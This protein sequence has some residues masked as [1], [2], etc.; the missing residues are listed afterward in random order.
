MAFTRAFGT[1]G[2]FAAPVLLVSMGAVVASFAGAGCGGDDTDPQAQGTG[3]A[4]A[5]SSAQGPGGANGATGGGQPEGVS[6]PELG[7]PVIAAY[8]EHGLLHLTCEADDDCYAALG[9]FHASNRFFFMDFIR[10]LV[11]GRLG[12]LVKAGATVLDLDF[13]NRHFF[14]TRKGEP[15]EE[16]LYEKASDRVKG[17][18]DAFTR[19]V[20]AW[21][22]DMRK[23]RNGATLTK[24]YEFALLVKEAIRDWEPADSAAVGL[25]VLNSLSNNSGSELALAEELPL[26]DPTLA[27]DLFSFRPVF[28]AFTIPLG[29]GS[30]VPGGPGAPDG[31]GSGAPWLALAPHRELFARASAV[32]RG[33]G[34]RSGP[35]WAS[36]DIGSNNWVVGP[37]RT[38]AGN[39]LLANDPHL[40]LLNPSI[41]F[42]VEIDAKSKGKGEYHVAGSTFPGLPAVM[43]GHNEAIGWGVTTAFWDLAD[44]YVETLSSDG[45]AVKL[46]GK[47]VPLFEK[48]FSFEDSSTG[49]TIEKTFRWVPHHGPVVSVDEEAGTAVSIRWTAH[50][51]GTDLDAFFALA[52]AGSVDEARE[53][54]KLAT[55]ANQNFVVVDTKGNFGW[56]P[57]VQ[58]PHRPWASA[59]LAPWL[60]LPGDGS[61]EW[62]GYVP[63]EDLPQLSNPAMGVIATAN[64]DLT[65]AYFDGDPLNDDQLALQRHDRDEGARQQRILD[66]LEAGGSDHTVETMNAIQGDTFVL[67]GPIVGT[68]VVI[69]ASSTTLEPDE[70]AVVDAL[71]GWQFTCPTGLDGS[72]AVASKPAADEVEVS[73]AVGCTAFHATLFS[74]LH[75]ALGDEIAAAGI[76]APGGVLKSGYWPLYLVTRALLDP[77]SIASGELFWDDVTTEDVV[78]TRDEI[79]LRGVSLAAD[80]L[81]ASGGPEKWQWGRLHTLTLRSIFDSF[82]LTAYNEGPWAAPGGLYTV[83][84]ASPRNRALP[85]EG[86]PFNFQFDAGPSV[87]FVVEAHPD[88]P[89]MTYQIPGGSDLHRESPFYNN[90]VAKWLENEPIDFPFGPDAIGEPALTITVQPA[91]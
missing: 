79:L 58:A 25:Y 56:F 46:E 60:P 9:Y 85:K 17:H 15:L 51:G 33:V 16:V 13:A 66:L 24:E 75:A 72:D 2:R 36:G 26:F 38:A 49:K 31:G 55:N 84:V 19:G 29:G 37:S 12:S 7:A 45:K 90:L 4:S 68:A 28:P 73:E 91:P 5:S 48:T 54:V 18:L 6:I 83:N 22:G 30:L 57:Y 88:G 14:A 63:I 10:N 35:S 81:A 67:Y 3:G 80:A 11:R 53:A 8:D 43:I 20:N 1:L 44:V 64:Q 62:D 76:E 21:I 89:R 70:Q 71:A 23:G 27:A 59:E 52:R 87:R 32:L 41:W 69:A 86:A 74:V 78:E 65:G 47:D 34:G 61:A 77:T 50:E 40:G 39:A 82:G 42:P